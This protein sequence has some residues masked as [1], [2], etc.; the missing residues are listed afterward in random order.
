MSAMSAS[1]G[2]VSGHDPQ[3]KN[4]PPDPLNQAMRQYAA[5]QDIMNINT[6]APMFSQFLQA[7]GTPESA[8]TDWK[9]PSLSPQDLAAMGFVGGHGEPMPTVSQ[10]DV[11]AGKVTSLTPQ[12]TMYLTT[13]R[14]RAQVAAGQKPGPW[15]SAV[16]GTT[17]RLQNVTSRLQTE[18]GED[19][20]TMKPRAARQET[21]EIGRLQ[22][23]QALLTA[24]QKRLISQSSPGALN[25]PTV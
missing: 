2:S 21:R 10:Q 5:R 7:G 6:H 20:S 11:A 12:Q 16:Q 15:V 1:K 22:A 3:I 13:Q 23:R 8:T 24:K 25:Q 4:V 19:L 9:T 18:Q 17:N 14:R